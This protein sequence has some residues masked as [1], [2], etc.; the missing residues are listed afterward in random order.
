MAIGDP[1]NNN[2]TKNGAMQVFIPSSAP[3][4][5]SISIDSL[6]SQF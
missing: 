6:I 5:S 2:G 1:W 4:I 3:I